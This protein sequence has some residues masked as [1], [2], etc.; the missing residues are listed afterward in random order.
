[1]ISSPLGATAAE[2][3]KG[4]ANPGKAEKAPAP[5]AKG[6]G[7]DAEA[8]EAKP[9]A[10]GKAPKARVYTFGG[11][12]VEGKLKTPQLLYFRGRVK[13]ELDTSTQQKRSFLEELDKSADEK[14]L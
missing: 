1:M 3:G 9:S 8:A 2:K 11:L 6:G 14:G 10:S 13:Q 7:A 5:A 12:D 4:K